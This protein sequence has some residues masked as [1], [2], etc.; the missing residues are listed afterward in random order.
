MALELGVAIRLMGEQSRVGTLRACAL[1]AEAEGLDALWVPDHIAIPPDDAEGSDG[2]YL[3]ALASLAWLAGITERIALGLGVLVLPYRPPLATAK[4]LATIQELSDGRLRVGTGIGW[5]EAEFRA[6]GIERRHRGRDS[7][8]VLEF[9]RHCFDAED[10]I[11]ESHGQ[12]FY[13]RPRPPRPPLLIGGAGPHALE[14]AA[15][16]G[17]GWLPMTSDPEKLEPAIAELR[18]RFADHGRSEAPQVAAFGAVPAADP[19]AGAALLTRL[20]EIG[21][22]AFIQGIRYQDAAGFARGLDPLLAARDELRR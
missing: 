19:A 4:W 13:F 12:P 2:R 21:V 5:M 16:Y 1:H 11:A 6:L 20:E 7:D 15:R 17:D 3:D 18:Q 8:A 22:T 14:R 9:I 10:D